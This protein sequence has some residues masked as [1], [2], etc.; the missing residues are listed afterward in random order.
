MS[1]TLNIPA[2]GQSLG[3]SR[4]QVLN[5]FAVLRSTI[6]AGS[7][8]PSGGQQPNHIDVNA[9]G[10]G[11]HIFVQMPVQAK[12]AL[13]LPLV[14]EGG[15]I[16]NT[17]AGSSELMYARDN[18]N[19][20]YQMTGPS[21]LTTGA[22]PS[23]SI[24]LF[25]TPTAMFLKWGSFTPIAG[26]NNVTYNSPFPNNLFGLVVTS[27]LATLISYTTSSPLTGFTLNSPSASGTINY[28]A[29]GN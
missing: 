28:F 2:T 29:I 4:T 6:S 25:G 21:T 20:Y 26:T 1:F 23:G 9:T 7:G 11:K 27:S 5:N 24:P 14:N 22:A 18:V 15:L 10:A 19:T 13:N 3:S 8:D 12:S 16:T 17:V